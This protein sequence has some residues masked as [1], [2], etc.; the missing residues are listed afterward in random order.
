MSDGDG[1]GGASNG[2]GFGGASDG[3]GFGGVADGHVLLDV[4]KDRHEDFFD[5]EDVIVGRLPDDGR[6]VCGGGRK[7]EF[8]VFRHRWWRWRVQRRTGSPTLSSLS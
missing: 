7:E 8:D 2:D 3:D 4:V 6:E 5:G 1:V